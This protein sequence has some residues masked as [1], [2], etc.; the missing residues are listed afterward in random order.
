MK[1]IQERV[2]CR[3]FTCILIALHITNSYAEGGGVIVLNQPTPATAVIV[4]ATEQVVL[5]PGFS[6]S[7][8]TGTFN[9]KIGTS[10]S[11]VPL[12]NIAEESTFEIPVASNDQNYIKTSIAMLANANSPMMTTIQY[13]DGLGRS[14]Q[15]VQMGISPAG[16]DLVA[17]TQYDSVGREWKNWFPTP[18]QGNFGQYVDE[19][20]FLSNATSRHNDSNPY[21]EIKYEP[22]PL[23][24]VTDQYGVGASW[25]NNSKRITTVYDTN[26]G[27]IAYF[28]VN[29]SGNL[30]RGNNYASGTL[31]K[32]TVS[33]EDG[34]MVTEFKDKLGRG[35]MKRSAENVDT[36]Y[37]YND[38]GQ[39]SFV[40]PPLA[41]DAL[42]TASTSG[43]IPDTNENLTKY[44]YIYRYDERGNPLQKRLPGCEPVYMVYDKADRLILSQDGIQRLKGQWTVNKYDVFGRLLYTGV[45]NREITNSEKE[46]VHSNV[47]IESWGTDNPF[48]DTGYTCNYFIDELQPLSVNYYNT[49]DFVPLTDNN[50][51][52]D[53]SKEDEYGAKHTSAKGLL[54]GTRT[55]L[56][57]NSGNYTAA[58]IYYDY[59]GLTIQTRGTNHL[60]GYDITYNKYNFTG[61]VL[62]T[63]KEHSIVGQSQVTELYT[64]TYDH[65]LRLKTTTYQLNNTSPVQLASNEYDELGRLVEKKRHNNTDIE[66]FEY[67]I[68]NWITEIKSGTTFEQNLY[69]NTG[70]PPGAVA[71]YNGNIAYN[72]W[73]YNGQIKGYKYHYDTQNR[74]TEAY[75]QDGVNPSN[76]YFD[77][78]FSYDK[79]G[80]IVG[81]WRMGNGGD[82]DNLSFGYYGNQIQWIIDYGGSQNQYNLKEYTERHNSMD[83][84]EAEFIYDTNGNMISDLDRDIVAIKYNLLNLP[85]TVQF[86]NGS[87]II[88]RYSADGR[89][90]GTRYVTV[91][92][93]LYQP[94]NP[95]EVLHGLEIHENGDVTIHGTDYVGNI[96]YGTDRCWGCHTTGE[97]VDTRWLD[98]VHN[99]EGYAINAQTPIPLYNYYRKDHLGNNREVWRA[100]YTWNGTSYSAVTVQRTQYYPSGLPWKSNTGDLPGTQPYKYG[101]KEFIE[102]HGY[103]SYDF[104]AR[105]RMGAVPVFETFDP[106]AEKRPWESPYCYAGNN[107]IR[108]I[109]PDGRDW[110][111]YTKAG[112]TEKSWN[113]HDGSTFE[114]SFGKDK[115]GNEKFETLSGYKAVVVFNGSKD[116][117]L[118]KGDNLFGEGAK[119]ASVTVYGPEGTDD[120]QSYQGFT[121]S[122]DPTKFGVVADG[123]YTVNKL[124][125]GERLGPYGSNLVV[126]NR[127]AR[128]PEQDN[129]NPAHP[130]R[131]PAYLTGVFIHRSNNNGWAGPFYKNGKWHGVSE[132]CLLVSP[133]QWSSFTKQLQPINNFLLQLRRK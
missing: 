12:F 50:I 18:T 16:A 124:K 87:Q 37:I 13:F 35:I 132:G 33:D 88:N 56:L 24:R 3:I 1:L 100:P 17:L 118:G 30:Q 92:S 122:S 70:L 58:A 57:N 47:I 69:Y 6:A 108:F 10:N 53:N 131:N 81:S 4:T 54:T 43:G 105:M 36:Y 117:K 40:L 79:Q 51:A 113:W 114:H 65:A 7:A 95:G 23:N 52:Y 110:F 14:V 59:K 5:K 39:L 38:L 78:I 28:Y 111:E 116:E 60:G 68:R 62:K 102:T 11:I 25:H 63:L 93:G 127:N 120:I 67:N 129:F 98:R 90:L 61:N 89:K 22:S 80:N 21:S 15:T 42:K 49:Y 44:A 99:E 2:L 91:T 71:C 97:P 74:M 76:E 101:G 66:E 55:Y 109:D 130:E 121:M 46:Y 31:F 20:S 84:P 77:E 72:T 106:L 104:H 41:A 19:S 26:D 8:S 128:I 86:K 112:E 48:H 94:L 29:E 115:D 96:E 119:L 45:I 73:T 82:I 103:D 85:D 32:T 34:K 133:T 107:P 125:E 75:F 123:T 64:Y 9:A 83:N 27:S 126:E